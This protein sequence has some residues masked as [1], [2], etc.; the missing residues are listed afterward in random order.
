MILYAY[1]VSWLP[2]WAT[3]A[4]SGALLLAGIAGLIW[5]QVPLAPY[6][7]IATIVGAVCLAVSMWTAGAGNMRAVQEQQALKSQIA[8]R[9][10]EVDAQRK[11][12]AS[13]TQDAA[14]A[15]FQAA[16]AAARALAAEAAAATIPDADGVSADTSGKIRDLWGK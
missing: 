3:L 6:R 4:A 16:D 5:G 12:I 15:Q 9:E 8:A 1:L 7:L 2:S 14:L 13:L 11:I 10:R